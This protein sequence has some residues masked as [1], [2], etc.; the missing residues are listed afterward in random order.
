MRAHYISNKV[1]V[2]REGIIA[3]LH[4]FRCFAARIHFPIPI[5]LWPSSGKVEKFDCVFLWLDV[6]RGSVI[7]VSFLFDS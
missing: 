7:L 1:F 2:S 5:W 4:L 3:F 6:L